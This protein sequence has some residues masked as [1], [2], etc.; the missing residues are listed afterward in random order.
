MN[1]SPDSLI[2]LD[3]TRKTSLHPKE[4]TAGVETDKNNKKYNFL[5]PIRMKWAQF[6]PLGRQDWLKTVSGN[7]EGQGH[8]RGS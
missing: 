2:V 3:K 7:V 8:F 5:N 1:L 6:R 4:W